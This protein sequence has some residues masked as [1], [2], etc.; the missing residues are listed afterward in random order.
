VWLVVEFLQHYTDF[1]IFELVPKTEVLEQP[2]LPIKKV[3]A[4]ALP[5]MASVAG[6]PLAAFTPRQ[7]ARKEVCINEIICVWRHS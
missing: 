7:K 5:S 6:K 2:H 1:A 4:N 3:N